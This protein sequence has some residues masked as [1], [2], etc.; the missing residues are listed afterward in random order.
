MILSLAA[1]ISIGIIDAVGFY[2]T[3]SLFLHGSS[4]NSKAIAGGLELLRLVLLIALVVVLNLQKGISI[5]PLLITAL[6]LSLGGKMALI[7]KRLRA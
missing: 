6:V 4:P 1:G 7:F 3:A 5:I 2:Y